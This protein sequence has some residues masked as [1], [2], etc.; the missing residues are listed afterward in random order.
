[1]KG[2]HIHIGII[3][4]ILVYELEAGKIIPEHICYIRNPAFTLNVCRCL[5][6][7]YL[8]IG[9]TG[10]CSD[11]V[12]RDLDT[13][14]AIITEND[15]SSCDG[16]HE[17]SNTLLPVD[18]NLFTLRYGTILQLDGRVLPNDDVTGRITF[19]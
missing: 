15:I 9:I 16:R 7:E 8:S 5:D 1:M 11:R 18:Q 10:Q 2:L 13:P 14:L 6:C 17:C 3:L 12:K 19:I 4:H